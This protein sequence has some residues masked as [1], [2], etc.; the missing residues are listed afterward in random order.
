MLSQKLVEAGKVFAD[1]LNG[2]YMAQGRVKALANGSAGLT[3]VSEA[4]TTSDLARAFASVTRQQ[5][6]DQYAALPQVWKDFA[7]KKTL[8]DFKPSYFRQLIFDQSSI[9]G[10]NGGVATLPWSLPNVPEQSEYPTT[11]FTTSQQQIQLAKKGLRVPF[12]WEM[13]INDEW[14]LIQS[15]PSN[16]ALFAANSEELEATQVLANAGGVN[17][18]TFSVANG[19]ANADNWPLSLDAITAAKIQVRHR[20]VNGRF[21]TVPKFRLV[22]PTSLEETARR[23]LNI[24]SLEVV[25]GASTD[26]HQYRYQTLANLGDVSLSVS[27]WLTQLDKTANNGKSWYLVPDSGFDGTRTSVALAFLQGHETPEFRQSGNTGL[28]LGGGDVPSLE[29]SLL[30]DDIEYR[31]R[32]VVTGGYLYPQGMFAS[33]GTGSAAPAE[34]LPA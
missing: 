27:N 29:G 22:V 6:V 13:V 15:L 33:N 7:Q 28:Y 34:Y 18:N 31:V 24:Q 4:L 3:G 12:S 9:V 23:I 17:S 10:S 21:V 16:L 30:N 5:L 25:Q 2:D 14:D 20:K 8:P 26:N 32:H 1:A 19:N 11:G